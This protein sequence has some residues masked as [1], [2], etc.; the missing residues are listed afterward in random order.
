MSGIVVGFPGAMALAA[1][2]KGLSGPSSD[3]TARV[4]QLLQSAIVSLSQ[5]SQIPA[6]ELVGVSLHVWLVPPWYRRLV[7]Y[8]LRRRL[9]G[10]RDGRPWPRWLKRRPALLC[11]SRFRVQPHDRSGVTF[12]P[13]IGLVGRC[14]AL[15]RPTEIHVVKLNAK[16]FKQAVASDEGW[17]KAPVT[18]TYHLDRKSA[19]MLADM[20]SEAAALVMRDN[21]GDAL[22]CVTIELPP[23]SKL[24]IPQPNTTVAKTDP[25]IQQL[26]ITT[27]FVQ[28]QLRKGG[29]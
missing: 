19:Q 29:D 23:N 8:Q 12:R 21:S 18:T 22:G 24:H 26:R 17:N 10:R 2:A 25:L 14:V 7:P 5:N 3:V 1:N 15:N 16:K 4:K 20:Y 9:K 13:G 11:L 27:E 6:Q 28:R